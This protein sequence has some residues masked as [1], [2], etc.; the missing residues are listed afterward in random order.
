MNI[1]GLGEK[2]VQNLV[3]RGMVRSLADLYRLKAENFLELDGFAEKSAKQLFQAIQERRSPR[4]DRFLYALGIR[5]A[6][7]HVARV[8][9]QKYRTLNRLSE[10][11]LNDLKQTREVG[12]EIAQSIHQF[13]R[14]SKNRKV[15][16]DLEKSGIIVEEMP[17]PK[18]SAQLK[19]KIF[20][21]TGE[22]K[23]YTREQAK[24]VVEEIGGRVSS[25]VSSNTDYLVA[26]ENP[27]SKLNAAKKHN[28]RI[29]DEKEFRKLIGA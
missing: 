25:S 28:V 15:L 5:H 26:G 4:L 24:R 17:A 21:F 27:G 6:G 11:D 29:F 12:P 10:A 3:E 23:S 14:E 20:V 22:L 2:T 18:E 16:K 7:E 1:E 19:G 9:A 8:L 13:F